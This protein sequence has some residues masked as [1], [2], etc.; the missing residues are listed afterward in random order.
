MKHL[1]VYG[2]FSP[3]ALYNLVIENILFIH[4][5]KN[6]SKQYTRLEENL[7]NFT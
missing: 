4:N 6:G 1:L 7:I 5:P 2:G 3:L